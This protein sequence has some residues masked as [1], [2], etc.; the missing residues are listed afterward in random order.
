LTGTAHLLGAG[1]GQRIGLE[2]PFLEAATGSPTARRRGGT[3]V[4]HWDL[5]NWIEALARRRPTPAGGSL[6]LVT[7]AGAAALTAKVSAIAGGPPG[8]FERL[9]ADFLE[10]ARLD[11][12]L[13]PR[14][15]ARPE[16]VR[17]ALEGEV[18]HLERG[19]EFLG[20]LGEV[21]AGLPEALVPDVAAG[22][23]LSRAACRTLLANLAVNLGRWSGRV[24]GLDG[25]AESVRRLR[26]ELEVA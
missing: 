18:A 5:G 22:E 23:R 16:A 19:V 17:A 15:D 2:P 21:F 24:D 14:A 12:A 13:Y 11:A 10:A 3:D 8:G 7:L 1:S 20:A 4:E 26:G 9:A 25:V 6:A